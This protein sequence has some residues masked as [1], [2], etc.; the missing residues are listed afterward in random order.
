MSSHHEQHEQPSEE[1]IRL[2]YRI[3]V[4]PDTRYAPF[5][6]VAG[7]NVADA[8]CADAEHVLRTVSCFSANQVSLEIRWVY[9]PHSDDLHSQE[10]LQPS[11]Q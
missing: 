5:Q 11:W 1:P 7:G 10:P 6:V 3:P 2:W 9:Q 4:N 8:I